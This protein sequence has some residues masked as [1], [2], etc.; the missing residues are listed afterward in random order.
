[1]H[2][3]R[4]AIDRKAA[5]TYGRHMGLTLEAIDWGYLL[6]MQLTGLFDKD[7]PRPFF[8]EPTKEDTN[9]IA[10]LGYSE[11]DAVS[12]KNAADLFA[13]PGVFQAAD[14]D[15]L[16]SKP[17]PRTFQ[18]GQRFGYITRVCPVEG[19]GGHRGSGERD[20]F[21]RRVQQRVQSGTQQYVD[22]W[23]A[24]RD[25]LAPKFAYRDAAQLETMSM[26]RFEQDQL[27]RRGEACKSMPRPVHVLRRP[28][29]TMCGDLTV[30]DPAAFE[31]LLRQGV[32]RHRGFGFGML[33]LTR[34]SGS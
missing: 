13:E 14:W 15:T 29:V 5:F 22:R 4:I 32:G 24:Y 21:L 19:H 11:L 30:Q 2:L 9:K 8:F 27:V 18:R 3:I 10:V 34:A 33:L 28:D 31:G 20:V 23:T 26:T 1:M 6:H 16:A 25:W 12:L 7:A 17:M